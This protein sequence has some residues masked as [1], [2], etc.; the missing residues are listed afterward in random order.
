VLIFVY[1]FALA[2]F[3]E[4]LVKKPSIHVPDVCIEYTKAYA[5]SVEAYKFNQAMYYLVGVAIMIAV[6]IAMI[7]VKIAYNAFISCSKDA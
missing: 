1:A 3:E 6:F 4:V 7:V 5:A 2:R